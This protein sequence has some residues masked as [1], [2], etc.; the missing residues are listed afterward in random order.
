MA[1]LRRGEHFIAHDDLSGSL[2]L[3]CRKLELRGVE[4]IEPG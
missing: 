1:A 4:G 2:D 3:V